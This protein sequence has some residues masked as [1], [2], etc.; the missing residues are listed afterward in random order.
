MSA[1]H[2]EVASAPSNSYQP[3]GNDAARSSDLDRVGGIQAQVDVARLS[4]PRLTP[5]ERDAIYLNQATVIN[6]ATAYAATI[7]PDAAQQAVST[8][9]G[10]TRLQ[11]TRGISTADAASRVRDAVLQEVRGDLSYLSPDSRERVA[12]DAA[13]LA[14]NFAAGREAALRAEEQDHADGTAKQPTHRPWRFTPANDQQLHTPQ[15]AEHEDPANGTFAPLWSTPL[16]NGSS[17]QAAPDV[18][19]G[20]RLGLY[21]APAA[22]QSTD[23]PFQSAF[24]ALIR[25]QTR[26]TPSAVTQTESVLNEAEAVT[27][28]ASPAPLPAQEVSAQPEPTV[29]GPF[30][31]SNVRGHATFVRKAA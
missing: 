3:S 14:A 8:Q 6:G 10:E 13:S 12:Q 4:N 29:E 19:T 25:P 11:G 31:I 5:E 7:V 24:D 1:V 16:Q 27:T 9:Q 23:D 2:M 20:T 26:P 21:Q 18:A 15:E 28:A 17:P 22:A 30:R